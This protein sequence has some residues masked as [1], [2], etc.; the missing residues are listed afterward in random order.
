[1]CEPI[2]KIFLKFEAVQPLRPTVTCVFFCGHL[3]RLLIIPS[4]ES[5]AAFLTYPLYEFLK[6]YPIPTPE[7]ATHPSFGTRYAEFRR[8]VRVEGSQ[9][10]LQ[11]L[12]RTKVVEG[13]PAVYRTQSQGQVWMARHWGG[14]GTLD[15]G[16]VSPSLVI[17]NNG[18]KRPHPRGPNDD[19]RRFSE[20]ENLRPPSLT[21]N[22]TSSPFEVASLS[23]P[24]HPGTRPERDVRLRTT[25]RFI[26]RFHRLG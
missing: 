14:P 9:E 12:A 13:A 3:G 2:H 26:D 19:Y 24:V 16:G 5:V 15:V 23:G 18:A 17:T 8:K 1:M 4:P 6:R 11:P 21:L 22:G 20:H 10:A 7:H 25:I